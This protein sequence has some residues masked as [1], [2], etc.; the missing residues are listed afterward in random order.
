MYSMKRTMNSGPRK[1]R[2]M[3]RISSS[4]IPRFTTMLILLMGVKPAERAASIPRSTRCTGKSTSFIARKVASSSAS[5]LTVRRR[6]PAAR[7]ACASSKSREPFVVRVRSRRLSMAASEETRRW[8]SRR[9]RGSP[10][11]SRIFS[12]PS[13]AKRRGQAGDFL[14]S[15]HVV[16]RQKVVAAS[17]DRLGHAI[18]AAEIAAIRHRDAQIAQRPMQ[19]VE[20]SGGHKA[21]LR[22]AGRLNKE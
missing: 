21:K 22:R 19:L 14:E 2:A 6:R 10:P 5:T 1:Y 16:L 9:N 15:Q 11:V 7:K 18:A 3:G 8:S 12:V 13:P 4:L 17:E 20:E